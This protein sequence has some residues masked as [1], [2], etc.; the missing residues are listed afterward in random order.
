MKTDGQENSIRG[1]VAAIW[2]DRWVRFRLALKQHGVERGHHEFYRGW[3]LGW[4]KFIKPRKFDE[5]NLE[6]VRLFLSHLGESGRKGWQIQQ[7]EEAL[8]ILFRDVEPR[9]WAEDWPEDLVRFE[10]F[11]L[12]SQ[13][14]G[15]IG[16]SP[17]GAAEQFAGRSDVGECPP[18]YAGF[19]DQVQEALRLAR[20]SYR[21]EK[22]YMDWV[23]RFVVFAQPDSRRDLAWPAAQNYLDYLTLVRRVSA[24]TLNQ[25]LSA[26]QF[27]F[28][29]VLK[30]KAGGAE[31]IKRPERRQRVPTVLTREEVKMLL[32]GMEGT[33][34]LMA[35]LLYGGGLRVMECVRLRVKDV[36]FGNGYIVVR[37]GKGDKDRRV[38]LPKVTVG[39][40]GAQLALCKERL[41]YTHV[42]NRP[43]SVVTSPLDRLEVPAQAE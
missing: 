28:T 25:A 37:S 3:V 18:K 1:R 31:G 26:L 12:T 34:R 13:R 36:D 41:I 24:S 17:L 30:K 42:M 22:T 27:L 4:M 2:E 5:G 19:L 33:G 39:R 29:A 38:P 10:P 43:G 15:E 20:Y 6:D 16:R 7:A 35:E 32:E 40:L 21:T 23:R 14:A 9:K 8:R 11:S